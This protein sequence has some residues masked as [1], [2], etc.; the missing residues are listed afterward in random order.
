MSARHIQ[1]WREL[2]SRHDD[3]LE[4]SLLWSRTAGAV[5]MVVLD[6]RFGD[7]LQFEVPPE[8]ALEACRH[9]FAFASA[10]RVEYLDVGVH[11]RRG[12]GSHD[13]ESIRKEQR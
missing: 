5:A 12:R 2:A 7:G 10:R 1:D 8:D 11:V 6:L 3:G 13:D 9:P 4:I